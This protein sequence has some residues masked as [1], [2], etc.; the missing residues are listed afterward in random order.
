M[1]HKPW[2][3]LFLKADFRHVIDTLSQYGL[4]PDPIGRH[5]AKELLALSA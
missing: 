5:F 2:Q 4:T 1:K 3:E